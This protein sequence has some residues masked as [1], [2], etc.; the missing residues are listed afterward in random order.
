MN[1]KVK[2]M[3]IVATGV[4]VGALIATRIVKIIRTRKEEKET[5]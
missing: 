3:A 2:T 1:N 4:T 5:K